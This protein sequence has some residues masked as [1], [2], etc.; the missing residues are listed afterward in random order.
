MVHAST[1]DPCQR[2]CRQRILFHL[3]V[4]FGMAIVLTVL[5]F[6]CAARRLCSLRSRAWTT[7]CSGLPCVLL[8]RRFINELSKHPPPTEEAIK[9]EAKKKD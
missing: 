9:E 4:F 1:A 7:S 5:V 8:W 3:R 2:L 6:W